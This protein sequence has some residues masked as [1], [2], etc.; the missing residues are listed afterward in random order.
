MAGLPRSSGWYEPWSWTKIG[1]AYALTSARVPFDVTAR[2]ADAAGGRATRC[3]SALGRVH[4]RRRSCSPSAPG[5]TRRAVWSGGRRRRARRGRS[6]RPGSRSRWSWPRTPSGWGSRGCGIE[7]LEPVL[8]AVVRVPVRARGG[9]RRRR[10]PRASAREALEEGDGRRARLVQ[11]VRWRRRGVRVGSWCSPS[12]RRCCSPRWRWARRRRTAR[13]VGRSERA[14]AIAVGASRAGAA[15][16]V[17]ARARRRRWA[18]PRSSR[19][20]RSRRRRSGWTGSRPRATRARSS[21]TRGIAGRGLVPGA[22]VVLG[23]PRRAGRRDGASAG[24]PPARAPDRRSWRCGSGALAG[25][26]F[27]VLAVAASPG[28]ARSRCRC[29]RACCRVPCVSGQPLGTAGGGRPR[30]GA[31]WAARSARRSVARRATAPPV[32]TSV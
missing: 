26:V 17:R 20:A 12:S 22:R 2:G 23:V 16:P 15:E 18:C 24:G 11:A 29:S 10:G 28:P 32:V 3:T 4:R 13:F 19:S 31:W 7:V 14:G 30:R 5:A 27:G 25:I 8:W 9:R 6:S 1:L 21:A